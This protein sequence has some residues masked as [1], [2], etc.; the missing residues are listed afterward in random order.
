[1]RILAL[2]IEPMYTLLQFYYPVG[3]IAHVVERQFG[4]QN[5]VQET[6]AYWPILTV[7]CSSKK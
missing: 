1:M 3:V 2:E 7:M 6:K 5:V 4:V